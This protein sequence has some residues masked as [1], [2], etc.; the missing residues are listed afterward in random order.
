MKITSIDLIAIES[1]L[2]ESFCPAF[3]RIHTD[4]SIAGMGEA[5]MGI[6]NDS[7]AYSAC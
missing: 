7:K 1:I 6:L 3:A 2:G 5:G 4:E